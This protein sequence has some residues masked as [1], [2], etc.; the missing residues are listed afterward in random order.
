MAIKSDRVGLNGA[1]RALL[2]RNLIELRSLTD[3]SLAD[4]RTTAGM[5]ASNL[6]AWRNSAARFRPLL[7]WRRKPGNAFSVSAMD[8]A[9]AV[10]ADRDLLTAAVG[11]LLQ[12]ALT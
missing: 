11:N 2:D 7:R 6:S 8:P 4:V 10:D 12:N 5:A 9:L 3:R 1:T